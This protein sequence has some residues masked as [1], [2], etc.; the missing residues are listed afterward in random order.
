MEPA[1][2]RSFAASV[3]VLLA[4]CPALAVEGSSTA[5]PIGG[6]DV[7]SA[8]LP[9]PGL[10]GG[11]VELY[12]EA[13]RFFDGNGHAVP[14]LNDLHLGRER[15][16]AFLLYVPQQKLFGGSFGLLAFGSGGQE[17]GRL[18]A[19]TAKRCI[20][21]AGDPYLEIDWSR[22]FGTMRPSQF[23]GAYPIAEGLTL[24]LG[25]GAVV[26]V[27]RYSAYDAAHQG[28]VIGNN[29]WD[30]APIV[31]FTYVSPP[32]I[33]DGTEASSKIHWNN[34]LPNNATQ[35]DTGAL[36]N[37]DFAVTEHI[38]RLQVGLAGFYAFQVSDDTLNGLAIPP[39]GRRTRLLELGPVAAY[40]LPELG[41]SIKLKALN[42]V[43]TDN[44]V[45]S[46][47][48]SFAFVAKLQ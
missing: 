8:Q 6:T 4:C 44:A 10:Y 16:G 3:I 45:A 9:P 17:C 33:S 19:P 35:Y 43:I 25:F 39:D 27:G 21:G 26:P 7:R 22:H 15:V 46:W 36:V 23:M 11:G 38:G 48:I 41:A 42:T 14:A 37:I 40:D 34:Y 28:L 1:T 29:I 31:A 2:L 47:G 20:A 32:V 5:G 24:E 30:F 12:A 13:N 18:F